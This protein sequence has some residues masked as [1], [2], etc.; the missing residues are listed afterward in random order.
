MPQVVLDVESRELGIAAG[1]QD[2]VIQ[3]YATD[4]QAPASLVHMDLGHALLAGPDGHGAYTRLPA[5]ELPPLYLAYDG[6]LA[7][8]SGKVHSDV[9]ARYERGD[10]VVLE[11]MAE[12]A[13]LADEAR[14]ALARRDARALGECM[15]RNFAAR[16]RM[17]GDGV[18]GARNIALVE[19]ANAHGL[20]AKFC[21]S[22]GAVVCAR[23]PVAEPPA[24]EPPTSEPPAQLDEP[25]T[26]DSKAGASPAPEPSPEPPAVSEP[27]AGGRDPLHA[28]VWPPLPPAGAAEATPVPT[29]WPELALCGTPVEPTLCGTPVDAALCVS[30][31]N[32]VVG[33]G[34]SAPSA[35]AATDVLSGPPTP[36]PGLSPW[37]AELSLSPVEEA[38]I[39]ESFLTKGFQFCRIDPIGPK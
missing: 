6:R 28:K 10:T 7:G 35:T 8:D 33:S 25:G 37:P 39:R 15:V 18:V 22:G 27:S 17:Y 5:R 30:Q 23:V 1:L 38:E 2:R 21:G 24:P 31:A 14:G 26:T 9:R 34:T 4:A 29:F 20:A 32:E 3:W 16:R 36:L 13:C 12:L 11:G 19:L